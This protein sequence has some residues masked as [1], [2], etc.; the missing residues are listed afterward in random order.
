MDDL[1]RTENLIARKNGPVGEIIFNN[2]T[3]LNAVS[4]D[5]WQRLDDV[6]AKYEQDPDIRVLVL[7]EKQ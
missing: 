2:P 7:A 3:K 1:V 4:L 5:M 6:L